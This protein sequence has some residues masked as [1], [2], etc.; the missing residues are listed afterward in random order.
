MSET[1]E[2]WQGQVVNGEFRLIQYLGS[3]GQSAVFLT[4]RGQ[5][6]RQKAAIKLVPADAVKPELQLS[7]WERAKALS[8]PNLLRVF[9]TGRCQL[10]GKSFLYV[11]ME[12]AEE[13]LSQIL[14]FRPLS[15][16]EAREML[17][18]LTSALEYLHGHGLVH[19][20]LKPSNVMAIGD[21]LKL[22]TDGVWAVGESSEDHGKASAYDA[23]EIGRGKLSPAADVWSLGITL[24]EVLTQKLPV[25]SASQGDPEV[26]ASLPE[27]FFDIAKHCI[28]TNPE[29]RYRVAEIKERL[30]QV[31]APAQK[32]LSAA[33]E[34]AILQGRSR[35]AAVIIG[36]ALL[37]LLA[38][39]WAR[40]RSPAALPAEAPTTTSTQQESVRRP[41]PAIPVQPEAVRPSTPDRHGASPKGAVAE[42]VLPNV[43]PSARNTIEGKVKVRVRVRV[44]PS[45]NVEV[46]TF[47][48]PGPSKYFARQA[49]GAAENWKFTP[50]QVGG[51]NV[52]SE[53][54]LRFEFGRTATQVFPA[55]LK[56]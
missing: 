54:S 41:A 1:W 38:I 31:P 37:G 39:Q 56:P 43:S 27:P 55:Q 42:Q 19:A 10:N 17:A 12:Y 16:A 7:H 52:A 6:N 32:T 34:T 47:D 50:P 36:I 48:S 4:E 45:G 2:Q 26:P 18:P 29:S 11:V 33:H 35:I 28:V 22:S 51:R 9:A 20:H 8:H 30:H 40:H 21:Q 49:M 46:A 5:E 3:S 25:P 23:P 15:T 24:V 13:D 53:W 44:D 14:P